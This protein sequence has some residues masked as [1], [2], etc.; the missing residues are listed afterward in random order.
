MRSHMAAVSQFFGWAET[1]GFC[2]EDPSAVLPS[3][4][5]SQH[6]PRPAPDSV[7]TEA[8]ARCHDERVSVMLMLGE[9]QGLRAGEIALVSFED[10]YQVGDEQC[11]WVHGKGGRD[12]VLPVWP[13]IAV[14]IRQHGP[15]YLFPGRTQGHLSS[16]HVTK[17]MS[18]QLGGFVPHSLRH[19]FATRLYAATKDAVLVQHWLG[20]ASL[21]T[22]QRYIDLM[23]EELVRG[24][25]ALG[26]PMPS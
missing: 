19:S 24:L 17:L 3:V 1:V 12:R 6:V 14:T 8:V 25:S 7:I 9:G 13:E 18:R 11:L 26:S 20:H 23:P 2:F 4:K 16:G 21:A 15:G 22:T 10:L 5:S